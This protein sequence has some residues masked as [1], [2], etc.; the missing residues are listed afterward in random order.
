MRKRHYFKHRCYFRE[1]P[2]KITLLSVGLWIRSHLTDG[3]PA[4]P[5]K[6]CRWW[7]SEAMEKWSVVQTPWG[8]EVSFPGDDDFLKLEMWAGRTPCMIN[9]CRWNIWIKTRRLHYREPCCRERVGRCGGWQGLDRLH[10]A[11]EG[12]T[13]TSLKKHT[14]AK[15]KKKKSHSRNMFKRRVM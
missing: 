9:P 11:S 3:F 6:G 13:T 8:V 15:E 2:C 10:R 4:K 7:V 1:A 12:K 14:I 5:G